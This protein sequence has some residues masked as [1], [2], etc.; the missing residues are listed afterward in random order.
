MKT[1]SALQQ[2]VM[3]E[4][5]WEPAVHPARIGVELKDGVVTLAGQTHSHVETWKAE[6]A[7]RWAERELTRQRVG[8]VA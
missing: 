8:Q 2:D 3:A 6:C 1:D 7:T 4:P 5:A